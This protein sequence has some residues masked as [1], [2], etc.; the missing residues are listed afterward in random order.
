LR[1]VKVLIVDDN[2]TNRRIV[3]DLLM[4]W[5]MRAC[6]V[7]DGESALSELAAARSANDAFA[8]VLT[9]QHMPGMDGF[10]LVERIRRGPGAPAAAIMMLT[11]GGHAGDLIRCEQLRVA[12]FLIKPVGRAELRQSLC[13]V[14]GAASI[15]AAVPAR[16][17]EVPGKDVCHP[18]LRVLVAEDNPVNQ[19][20]LKRLLEKRG[21]SVK[22]ASNGQ[23]AL[24]AIEEDTFDL[25]FMD[26]QMP[27]LDGLEAVAALRARESAT[28][29]R[30]T[31]IAVTAHA[32]TGDRERCVEAGMDGYLSKPLNPRELDEL[33]NNLVFE[34]DLVS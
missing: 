23:L 17:G 14:L 25:V 12:A 11:A 19:L 9:D 27:V 7:A 33:L 28:G 1:G 6:A 32:M 5:Q 22:I 13:Q 8:L 15:A 26:V 2:P 34:A 21:H 30:L 4:R 16:A 18:P 10:D 20:L 29:A 31:V 3:L 24:K